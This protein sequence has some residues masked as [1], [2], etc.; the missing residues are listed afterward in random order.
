ML[1]GLS[2]TLRKIKDKIANAIFLDRKII[3]EA[4]EELKYALIEADVDLD[5]VKEIT[6]KIKEQAK[7][8]KIKSIEKKDQLIK[9]IYDEIIKILGKE[10]YELK[11]E[12]GKS[13]KIMFI[14]LYGSGK[15]TVIAKLANYYSK[16][17]FKVCVLGLDVHRPAAPEQLEQLSKKINVS[18]FIDK[19]EKNPLTIYEKYKNDI[20]KY[21]LC[22]IDT[23]G[24]H[25]LDSELIKEIKKLEKTIMPNYTLLVIPADIGQAAKKQVLEFKKSCTIHGIIVNRMDS[26]AKGGGALTASYLTNTRVYFIG[27]GEHIVDIEKFSPQSFVSRLLGMGDLKTLIEKIETATEKKEIKKEKFTLLDFYNQIESMQN[28]GPFSKLT[29]MI[30]GISALKE[31]LKSE[32]I[33][34]QQE[35]TK[36]WKYAIQSM[37]KAEIE[38]PELL[39]KQPSRITRISKGSGVKTSEIKELL[40]Q[41]KMIKGFAKT[42]K[43][44]DIEK[45]QKG[46]IPSGISRKQLM[47]LAKKYRGKI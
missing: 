18:C 44:I 43:E 42:E 41:Y 46:Q 16:R 39:E 33:D 9:F 26:S 3:E 35:K 23:A 25:D 37:T 4:A 14:G 20:K 17:G 8:E 10:E 30:P 31:K 22:F 21:D 45:L 11:L 24:R 40:T 12:K 2:N 7:E 28:L 6:N 32:T 34:E 27:T 1:S 38:N 36:R 15:T 47:K 29:E 13:Q 5:L 19:Q